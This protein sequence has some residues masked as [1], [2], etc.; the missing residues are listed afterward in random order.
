MSRIGKLPIV[1]PK[2]VKVDWQAPVVKVTAGK[3][4]LTRTIHSDIDLNLTAE[5]IEVKPKVLTARAKALWGLS[6]TLIN[7][8]V[9]GVSGGFSKTLEV[10]GVGWRVEQLNPKQLKLSLGFSHPVIFDLPEGV[11]AAVDAKTNK[12]TITSAD[13]ELLGLT[14]ARL[15]AYRRPEPYKGKGIKYEGERIARKVGKAGGK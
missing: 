6:R 5:K 8:M 10:I 14:A 7:N 2:G 13:N 15:R 1:L 4:T 9:R 11:G 12:I 3:T